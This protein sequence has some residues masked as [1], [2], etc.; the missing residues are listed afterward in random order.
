MFLRARHFLALVLDGELCPEFKS[1]VDLSLSPLNSQNVKNLSW[2]TLFGAALLGEPAVSWGAGCWVD[3][4]VPSDSV[5]AG[6]PPPGAVVGSLGLG[7]DVR[8]VPSPPVPPPRV[9]EHLDQWHIGS[10]PE[11]LPVGPG[12]SSTSASRAELRF[13]AC[14]FR[15]FLSCLL[16]SLLSLLCTYLCTCACSV[17]LQQV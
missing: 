7:F 4:P 9:V 3:S 2:G 15:S 5:R 13:P 17:A 1:P 16:C 14:L 10:A 6:A 11:V 8:Q 12:G